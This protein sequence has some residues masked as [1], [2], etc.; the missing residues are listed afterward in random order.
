M[1]RLYD[2]RSFLYQW[3]TDAKL[4]VDSTE[5]KEV[6]FCNGSSDCS[7]VCEVYDDGSLKVADIPNILLQDYLRIKVYAYDGC[8]T[9]FDDCFE[10][11]KR[12]KPADYVY[13]ET[14]VKRWEKYVEDIEALKEDVAELE[15]KVAN[16][17]IDEV[18]EHAHYVA[19]EPTEK[20]EQVDIM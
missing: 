7:L 6:H 11:I 2:G 1:F 5:I 12:S 19:G 3:D 14:E 16:I 15:D 8:R 18:P 10:V 13:T 17:K 9:R 4:I 20:T